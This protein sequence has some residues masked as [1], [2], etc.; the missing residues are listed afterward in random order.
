MVKNG[1]YRSGCCLS[2]IYRASKENLKHFQAVLNKVEGQFGKDSNIAIEV[3]ILVDFLDRG[4]ESNHYGL[5][6]PEFKNEITEDYNQNTPPSFNGT[7]FF[8]TNYSC[9]SSCLSFADELLQMPKVIHVGLPTFGD[10]FYLEIREME[11]PSKNG[12]F[13]IPMKVFRNRPRGSNESYQPTYRFQGNIHDRKAYEDW[14]IE[15]YKNIESKE[16]I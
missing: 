12:S 2:S 13:T 16:K 10:T 6:R 3:K 1:T 4:I 15:L 7:V 8:I 11:L 14:I 5:V 9:G